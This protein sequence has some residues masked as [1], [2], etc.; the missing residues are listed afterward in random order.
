[1]NETSDGV[2]S[3]SSLLDLAK[4]FERRTSGRNTKAHS[5]KNK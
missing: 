1:M 5:L 4:M 2:P 3:V